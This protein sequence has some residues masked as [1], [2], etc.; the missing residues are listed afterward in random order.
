MNMSLQD[1]KRVIVVH[2]EKPQ[3]G[4]GMHQEFLQRLEK[5][6]E[7]SHQGG[8][9]G[10][11]VSGGKTREK[12]MAEAVV[13]AQYL[14]ERVDVPVFIEEHARTTIQNIL[15]VKK[16]L[17]G[18]SLEYVVVISSTSRLFRLRYLYGR[19][20]PEISTKVEFV[21]ATD[22]YGWYFY[23]LEF[24]YLLYAVF[25]VRENFLSRLTNKIF[26]NSQ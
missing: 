17:C 13:G 10:I 24:V 14:R 21:G 8:V 26:R 22:S 9:D 15:F 1:L 20:W 4:C 11:V 2:G 3:R 23:L 12:C 19:L 5:A 25:D 18:S 7:V 16:L 6:V